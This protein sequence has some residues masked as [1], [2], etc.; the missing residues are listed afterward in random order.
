M[1]LSKAFRLLE[2]HQQDELLEMLEFH[3]TVAD[4]VDPVGKTGSQ[5]LEREML[6]CAKKCFFAVQ[7]AVNEVKQIGA[8][9]PIAVDDY[10]SQNRGYCMECD[11]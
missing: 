6:E 3:A 10:I 1:N 8:S 5:A 4:S 9:C 11:E 7:D 2:E